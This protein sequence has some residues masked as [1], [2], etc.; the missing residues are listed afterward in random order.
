MVDNSN[1]QDL[2]LSIFSES[3]FKTVEKLLNKDNTYKKFIK[4][5]LKGELQ[6]T[7]KDKCF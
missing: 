7:L 4:S 5:N 3:F 1:T 6:K 2:L